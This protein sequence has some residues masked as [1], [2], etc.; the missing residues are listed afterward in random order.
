MRAFL[1]R[2]VG[3]IFGSL[4]L[5]LI[6]LHRAV[7]AVTSLF[8][9]ALIAGIQAFAKWLMFALDRERAE[10]SRLLAEQS[11]DLSELGVIQQ[12]SVIRDDAIQRRLWTV[13]HTVALNQ[14]GMVLVNQHGWEPAR[15]HAYLR[16]VVES[17]PGLSYDAGED[18]ESG[19]EEASV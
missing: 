9:G 14:I 18:E 15:V 8:F 16:G 4:I 13:G 6:M 11:Q 3:S 12:A 17:I 19:G 10:H 7:S 2:A 5:L 1:F